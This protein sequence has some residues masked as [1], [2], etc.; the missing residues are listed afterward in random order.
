MSCV[1]LASMMIKISSFSSCEF[2]RLEATSSSSPQFQ[3]RTD[4]SFGGSSAK[5]NWES[6][7]TLAD[8]DPPTPLPPQC[9]EWWGEM[10]I[11]P[12]QT[13][14]V[15]QLSAE[16]LHGEHQAE[17]TRARMIH[18]LTG[19]FQHLTVWADLVW[20]PAW[21]EVSTATCPR[22]RISLLPL[23]VGILLSHDLCRCVT[24]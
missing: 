6:L 1:G 22:L 24:S 23:G 19:V 2:R 7:L 10:S 9:L 3:S 5:S 13:N 17:L 15:G 21:D 11:D 18:C 12:R 8:V 20:I 4:S 14:L 16:T